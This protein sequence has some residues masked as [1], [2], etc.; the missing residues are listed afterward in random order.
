MIQDEELHADYHHRPTESLTG[1]SVEYLYARFA[2]EIFLKV[3]SFQHIPLPK[4]KD[5]GFKI[6]NGMRRELTQCLDI[7]LLLY[8]A[9]VRESISAFGRGHDIVN[10]YCALLPQEGLQNSLEASRHGDWRCYGGA[11]GLSGYCS[12]DGT[13]FY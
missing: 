9:T 6:R 12:Y 5:H 13:Q 7:N 8:D 3:I 10:D 2:W 1:R 4:F 11:S